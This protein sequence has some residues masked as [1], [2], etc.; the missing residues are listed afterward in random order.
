MALWLIT[1]AGPPLP[2]L[3]SP[4][5]PS[6]CLRLAS[7]CALRQSQ[8]PRQPSRLAGAG[9]PRCWGAPWP[10]PGLLSATARGPVPCEPT[11]VS[12]AGSGA[13]AP[14]RCWTGQSLQHA[15]AQASCH[16]GV[17]AQGKGAGGEGTQGTQ[18]A[19]EGSGVCR[20]KP[21]AGGRNTEGTGNRGP[22]GQNT[23]A[24]RAGWHGYMRVQAPWAQG[25][26]RRHKGKAS[27]QG[28]A[29]REEQ[30]GGCF[31]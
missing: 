12:V 6:H 9:A 11:A 21:G 25:P 20:G 3:T 10:P 2:L 29:S 8:R 31:R 22:P 16:R 14:G 15:Q 18:G 17:P 26:P 13:R 7:T 24:L 1:K 5:Q 23:A 30:G 28:L 19:G 27:R 4:L